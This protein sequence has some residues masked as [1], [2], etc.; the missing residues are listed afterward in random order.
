M[1]THI[2]RK[3]RTRVRIW[4]T[5]AESPLKRTYQSIGQWRGDIDKYSCAHDGCDH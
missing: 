4:E 1:P 5:G 2:V 3:A